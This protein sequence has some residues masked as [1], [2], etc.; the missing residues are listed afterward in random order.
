M[1]LDTLKTIELKSVVTITVKTAIGP[2]KGIDAPAMFVITRENSPRGM[3]IKPTIK[4]YRSRRPY[5][6]V[7]KNLIYACQLWIR[8][9]L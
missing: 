8:Q 1:S 2:I 9:H 3:V 6:G 4:T 5:T 7:I